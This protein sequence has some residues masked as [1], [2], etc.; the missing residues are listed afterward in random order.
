MFQ[1]CFKTILIVRESFVAL[2]GSSVYFELLK[3]ALNYKTE[4]KLLH[5]QC[6]ED[7]H[8]CGYLM[9]NKSIVLRWKIILR[10][11]INLKV[12]CN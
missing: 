8:L 10:N 9:L 5:C 3:L 2:S 1:V 11:F 12:V 4:K 6:E 7:K